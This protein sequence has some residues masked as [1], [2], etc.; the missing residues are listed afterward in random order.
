MVDMKEFNRKFALLMCK[1]AGIILIIL[2]GMMI[3][4]LPETI[5]RLWPP[6]AKTLNTIEILWLAGIATLPIAIAFGVGLTL[7]LMTKKTK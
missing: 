3:Y 1:V 2:G 6:E 5:I 4:A 7:L